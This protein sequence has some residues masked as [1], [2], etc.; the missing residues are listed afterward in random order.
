MTVMDGHDPRH[1]RAEPT[2]ASPVQR[3]PRVAHV[4]SREI[5][6]LAGSR[7]VGNTVLT[8]GKRVRKMYGHAAPLD[9]RVG[10][11]AVPGMSWGRQ[12]HPSPHSR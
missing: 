4:E 5:R 2:A 1:V 10:H 7:V 6:S 11:A 9:G 12:S 3:A 8:M